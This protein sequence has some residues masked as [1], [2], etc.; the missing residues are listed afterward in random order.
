MKTLF[1]KWFINPVIEKRMVLLEIDRM[2]IVNSVEPK[3][4]QQQKANLFC[5]ENEIQF[6]INILNEM[7]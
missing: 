1:K 5:K 2:K 4:K 3:M 7:L 6:A